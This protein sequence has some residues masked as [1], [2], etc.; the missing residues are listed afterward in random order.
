M[1]SSSSLRLTLTNSIP[2]STVAMNVMF[3]LMA[4]I[5]FTANNRERL[6][7]LT[8]DAIALHITA[9]SVEGFINRVLRHQVDA[10]DSTAM[11]HFQKGLRLLRHRL[12]G[13]D[14]EIKVSDST[15]GV[16]LKLASAAHFDGDY[17]ASRQH[18]EGLRTMV[19]LRGGLNVFN[20][21]IFLTELLR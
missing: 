13:D 16:V 4:A 15:M 19:D 11:L 2:V 18:M 7:P 1:V 17:E 10:I 3:P 20:G 6:Y 14:E 12:R 21:R 8:S 9:F 5:G